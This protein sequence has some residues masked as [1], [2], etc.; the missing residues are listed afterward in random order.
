MTG[1]PPPP[2]NLLSK[3]FYFEVNFLMIL[4]F[5]SFSDER[6]FR[7]RVSLP[8][9]FRMMMIAVKGSDPDSFMFCGFVEDIA[10]SWPL[11]QKLIRIKLAVI[12]VELP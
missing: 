7:L 12:V 11:T 3:F 10:S 1:S 9:L 5:F 6:S 4:F 8:S 2:F